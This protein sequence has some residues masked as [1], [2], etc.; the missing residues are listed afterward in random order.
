MHFLFIWIVLSGNVQNTVFRA[1]SSS[2]SSSSSDDPDPAA[3]DSEPVEAGASYQAAFFPPPSNPPSQ[4]ESTSSRE[5][6][7][8]GSA[9][10]S[11]QNPS[12]PSL[13]NLGGF[14]GGPGYELVGDI[15]ESDEEPRTPC[16]E[17]LGVRNLEGN[18]PYPRRIA[19]QFIAKTVIPAGP[20][21]NMYCTCASD[22]KMDC[23][24]FV[25]PN[26]LKEEVI[27]RRL[28]TSNSQELLPFYTWAS[29]MADPENPSPHIFFDDGC[30][31]LVV[32]EILML[33]STEV[34]PPL[35]RSHSSPDRLNFPM[36]Q[37]PL[38]LCTEGSTMCCIT[39]QEFAKGDIVYILNAD[40]EKVK[41]NRKVV[42]I[43]AQGLRNLAAQREDQSFVDPLKRDSG[44]LLTIA[45]N[46]TSY[47]IDAERSSCSKDARVALPDV[48]TSSFDK[49][50][51]WFFSLHFY[52]AFMILTVLISFLLYQQNDTDDSVYIAFEV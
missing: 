13:T 37:I 21:K 2:S 48:H 50:F 8:P 39:Q 18:G 4:Q 42:C 25:Q 27:K 19:A 1:A 20:E 9:G 15:S 32:A 38:S 3:N 44:R 22:Q 23:R 14:L 49:I 46:Y 29:G 41:L 35:T 24:I 11:D 28:D 30:S 40:K 51:T 5:Q 12:F 16:E 45:Q 31:P 10:P 17:Q 26:S 34:R 7:R 36:R 33:P 6:S 52:I 43:S 47:V